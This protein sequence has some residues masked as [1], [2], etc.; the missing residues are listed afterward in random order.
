MFHWLNRRATHHAA[1]TLV[2]ALLCLPNLG[3]PG[4]W[5]ID[6][7]NNAEAGQEM[8]HSGNYVVPTFNYHT[9]YDKPA[10]LYWLQV[11]GYQFFGVNEFAARLPSALAA[12][13][14]IGATYEIGRQMFGKRAAFLA[15]LILASSLCFC[16]AAHFANPDALLTAFIA[17]TMLVFWHD[18]RRDGR[19]YFAWTG[20]TMGLAM[21]AKGPV[22][23]AMPVAVTS[24]F[25]LWRRQLRRLFDVRLFVAALVFI[26]VA[27]PWYIWV[28]VETKGDWVYQFWMKH[29]QERITTA[30]ENH[31]GPIFYYVLILIAGLAPWSVF[32]GPA[33]WHAWK[34][35]R[36]PDGSG[37]LNPMAVQFLL[38]WMAVFFVAF[39]L[40]RTKLPNYVLPLY[41]AAALL[42]AYFLD[43]WRRGLIGVPALWL[44][45]SL[46]CLALM[47]VGVAVGLV[48]AGDALPIALLRGRRFPGLEAWAWLGGVLLAGA[49][50]GWW[51]VQRNW[52]GGV[53]AAVA[54]SAVLFTGLL[55]GWGIQVIDRYKAPRALACM[56]PADQLQRE[57]K[58]AAYNY[59]QRRVNAILSASEFAT[60]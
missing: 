37:Q 27:A 5:D 10:L 53:I 19:S 26:L 29:H 21:L 13:L 49:G 58:L 45:V 30:M 55:A 56:L 12:L 47:G 57:V 25:L 28:A 23:L 33:G 14:A 39:S 2:W 41:P 48:I 11:V 46:G 8:L 43:Q 6:E 3:G 34:R 42:L 40:V 4:L 50:L 17:L 32:L 24:L 44:R 59:F 60:P 22:G 35:L 52:R 36:Q 20:A 1:L 18:Y 31:S 54:G 15:G 7:G 9:R 51:C 38:C 16:G